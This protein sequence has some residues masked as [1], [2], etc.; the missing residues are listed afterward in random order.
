MF[1]QLLLTGLILTTGAQYEEIPPLVSDRS[2]NTQ[3]SITIGDRLYEVPHQDRKYPLKTRISPDTVKQLNSFFVFLKV[4]K[5]R[6]IALRPILQPV[7]EGGDPVALYWL[8][9]TYDLAE[10]GLGNEQDAKI[11]GSFRSAW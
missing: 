3:P 7:A 1:Q 9:K 2:T 6:V 10:F 4:E 5:P 11:A 8:A